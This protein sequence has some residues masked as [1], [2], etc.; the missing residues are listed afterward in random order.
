MP[1]TKIELDD[2]NETLDRFFDVGD[3][4]EHFG[5][6][7]EATRVVIVSKKAT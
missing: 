3:M 2:G 4:E 5:V 7:H 1:S 6:T